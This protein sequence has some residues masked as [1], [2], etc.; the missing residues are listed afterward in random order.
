MQQKVT[1]HNW[2]RDTAV[3]SLI[4][5]VNGACNVQHATLQQSQHCADW[6]CG[7]YLPTSICK[8]DS[9]FGPL[10]K[11]DWLTDRKSGAITSSSL[12]DGSSEASLTGLAA[13]DILSDRHL[14]GPGKIDI[15][16]ITVALVTDGK[17]RLKL[18]VDGLH[19]LML[20]YIQMVY[21]L[22]FEFASFEPI[23]PNL[24]QHKSTWLVRVQLIH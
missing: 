15:I 1:C 11:Q 10:F 14:Q 21:W 22:R 5:L 6:S 18:A 8:I 19:A 13:L 20:G 17:L 23:D 24:N 9:Q 7:L 2:L 12:E 16:H 4:V 3:Q